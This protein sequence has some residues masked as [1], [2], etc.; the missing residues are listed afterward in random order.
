MLFGHF[1]VKVV[2]RDFLSGQSGR[3][4]FLKKTL[5]DWILL[6]GVKDPHNRAHGEVWQS[7]EGDFL[8]VRT[9]HYFPERLSLPSHGL[10][11]LAQVVLSLKPPCLNVSSAEILGTYH[12]QLRLSF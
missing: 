2:N 8:T 10:D 1:T 5:D 7:R 11:F 9:R 12:A 3:S 4:Y 6:P